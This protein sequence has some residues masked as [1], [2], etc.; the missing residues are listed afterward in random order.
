[1]FRNE[2]PAAG[3]GRR[4]SDPLDRDIDQVGD[5]LAQILNDWNLL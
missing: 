1:M 4:R 2:V 3:S 5:L